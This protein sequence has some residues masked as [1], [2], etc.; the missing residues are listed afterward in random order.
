[1]G[2]RALNSYLKYG[3]IPLEDSV[4]E[5]FHTCEQVSR[6]LEYAYDDFV[7]AQVLQ[8][9]E[10]SDDYFPDPQKAGLYDTL[11][12]R[13]RYYRNVINP[14]TGYAQGRYADGSFLTDTG[15]A[16]SFTRFIT[17]GAPCHYTWYAPMIYTD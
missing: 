16:F 4:P 10:T 1:M 12:I 13:A 11:M 6:T 15:N 3:Y 5:A 8:K 9:L 14:G 2:R 7:L 17:E